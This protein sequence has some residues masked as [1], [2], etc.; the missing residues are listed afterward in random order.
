MEWYQ[1]ACTDCVDVFHHD[2]SL[3]EHY[4]KHFTLASERTGRLDH[5]SD[6]HFAILQQLGIAPGPNAEQQYLT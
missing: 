3:Q 2:P 5:H 1:S 4:A 6:D